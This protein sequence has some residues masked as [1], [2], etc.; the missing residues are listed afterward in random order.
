MTVNEAPAITSAGG[1]HV[2]RRHRRQLHRHHRPRLPGPD[3]LGQHRCAAQPGSASRTTATAPRRSPARPRPAAAALIALTLN[4]DQPRTAVTQDFELTVDEAPTITSAAATTFTVG[5]AG[6]FTVTTGHAYPTP[7]LSIGTVVLPV[8]S[9]LQGQRRRHRHHHRQ[10]RTRHRPPLQLPDRRKQRRRPGRDPD[11]HDDDRRL[12]SVVGSAAR[13]REPG[14]HTAAGFAAHREPQSLASGAEIAYMSR[15]GVRAGSSGS[16]GKHAA[17]YE[18]WEP[19]GRAD[20]L[21]RARPRAARG[22]AAPR[23]RTRGDA[24]RPRWDRQEPARAQGVAQARAAFPGRR[25]DGGAGG[26]GRSRTAP[27]RAR[28][29]DAGA[30]AARRRRDRGRAGGAPAG[31][32]AAARARQLRAP[33]RRLPRPRRLDRV[34]GGVGAGAL[35]EPASGSGWRGRRPGGDVGARG[36]RGG[37]ELPLAGLAEVEAA[38]AAGRPRG[39]RR[40]GFALVPGEPRGGD[41][42]LPSSGRLAAG[43]RAGGGAALVD[44][45]R[46][47]AGAAGR[48]LPPARGRRSARPRR[49][50]RRCAQRSTGAT[51][52]SARRNGSCGVG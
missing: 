24:G 35:H 41:R 36:A 30:G 12:T 2:H 42:D 44:E 10:T 52:C 34:E 38:Q 31:S 5:T 47:S 17:A 6:S 43:D 51:S 19:S 50:A 26:A 37:G 39:R 46:G 3:A 4:G 28:Q 22:E 20:Q 13:A 33:A 11:V 48:P 1:G 40:S 8:G 16:G 9:Q 15:L 32:A 45:R 25:L 23:A 7:T 21:R 27:V 18:V 29:G 14:R 49:E